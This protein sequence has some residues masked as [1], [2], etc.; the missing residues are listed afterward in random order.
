M[1]SEVQNLIKAKFA[2]PHLL[3]F[4]MLEEAFLCSTLRL[5]P[6]WLAMRIST[7]L[8]RLILSMLFLFLFSSQGWGLDPKL[9]RF[10]TDLRRQ[11]LFQLTE[12]YCQQRLQ[13]SRLP[14]D[15]RLQ[16]TVELARTFAQH[17]TTV[18]SEQQTGLYQRAEELLT[19]YPRQGL[20]ELEELY[21]TV[22]H[23]LLQLSKG[24]AA[25]WEAEL[26]STESSRSSA[27]EDLTAVI[28]PASELISQTETWSK[29]R[30]IATTSAKQ[31]LLTYE[32]LL[33]LQREFRL[34]V[35]RTLLR[36]AQLE[37]GA[38][39]ETEEQNNIEPS[40]SQLTE[41]YR[42]S[43]GLIEVF[44]KQYEH[45]DLYFDSHLVEA[46]WELLLDRYQALEKRLVLLRQRQLS[47]QIRNSLM[48][49]EARSLLQ[50]H[51]IVEASKKLHQYQQ[52]GA[53]SEPELDFLT[54]RAFLELANI[55]EQQQDQNLKTRLMENIKARLIVIE[56]GYWAERA[57]QLFQRK[58]QEINYGADLQEQID[59]AATHARAEK[60]EAAVT[61]YS[62]ALKLAEER[63]ATA[64]RAELLYQLGVAQ[65]NLQSYE[66][67]AKLFRQIN[68]EFPESKVRAR[69]HLMLAY[70]TGR[71]GNLAEAMTLLQQHREEFP[72]SATVQEATR[73]LA[74]LKRGSREYAT[75]LPL[76]R[77][78]L[79]SP[80]ADAK[81]LESLL[82]VYQ[83]LV[84]EDEAVSIEP[85]KLLS[86]FRQD[87]PDALQ[88]V[89]A[90]NLQRQALIR[91][92]IASLILAVPD[93]QNNQ[94]TSLLAP[95]LEKQ[96]YNAPT[97]TELRPQLTFLYSRFLLD[98]S[99]SSQQFDEVSRLPVELKLSLYKYLVASPKDQAT[100]HSLREL[101][102]R[103][104]QNQKAELS[105]E[106]QREFLL[107]TLMRKYKENDSLTTLEELKQLELKLKLAPEQ[108]RDIA[109]RLTDSDDPKRL[110]AA[111]DHWKR[112]EGLHQAG[113][114]S[115]F[116]TRYY[117]IA[118]LQKLGNAEEAKKLKRLTLLLHQLPANSAWKSRFDSL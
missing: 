100:Y 98:S 56:P 33:L 59:Q 62:E 115:W 44:Q 8:N 41:E 9:T 5:A 21:L 63:N 107:I 47:P 51:K 19:S 52:S 85:E 91:L 77:E 18:S 25:Y 118:L 71:S 110:D 24:E 48:S 3:T 109:L 14:H 99:F 6:E 106:N 1:D 104:L 45:P 68:S 75:A 58:E 10:T 78:L 81:L 92:T 61:A 12:S 49:L 54:I 88:P 4:P 97:F 11:Q 94:I 30:T 23:H 66:E 29:A 105:P 2:Y 96:N 117:Q 16:L 76:Y 108:I 34:N 93:E 17:A 112:L 35:A 46:E 15:L 74:D 103:Q 84:F 55:A 72:S 90:D 40:Q 28:E 26:Y 80:L 38:F 43:T 65:Y 82:N 36:K 73:L 67:A 79:D 64:L 113:S 87:F 101:M 20:N 89:S 27:R 50:Q 37:R 7:S 95:L 114:E 60:W 69:A 70:C 83:K 22:N 42:S 57:K 13:D 111:L 86:L 102:E 116:E 32:E 53:R 39:S 31:S